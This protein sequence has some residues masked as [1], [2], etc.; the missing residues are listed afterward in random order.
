MTAVEGHLPI[1]QV[2]IPLLGAV[3]AAFLRRGRAA[4]A[5]TLMVSW[6][7]PVVAGSLLWRVLQSGPI[8]YAI[9]GWEPP[10]GI[11]YRIDLL[12]EIVLVLVSAVGAVAVPFAYRSVA[13][14]IGEDRQA[15]FYCMYLLCLAGLLGITAT[16][17]AFNAFV[18]LEISSLATY[19]LIALGRD[20]R[21]LIAAFQYLIMGTI[22][23]TFY[24]I[25]V[26]LLYLL[27]G[28]LN[29]VDIGARL[30]PAWA[31]H[32]RAVVAA[33][34]FITV[35]VSLKLALFPL[36]TW[37]PN[38]YAY[39]P[40]WVTAFL[41]ATATKVAIYLLIRFF[42]SI[43]GVAIDFR[44]LP[45]S[46]IIVALS[47]AAMLVASLVAVFETN[48]KRMLAYSSVAQIGYITLGIGLADQA[49]LTG[50]LVHIVNH[51]VMKAGLFLAAGAIVYR[52]GTVQ[53]RSWPVSAARCQ[54]R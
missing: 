7:M 8:S 27:T 28:S 10:W 26:G 20:R 29:M 14:E 32:S 50:G 49:G 9:G 51:A 54:S 36:H 6:V 31:D 38:A 30:S 18:F 23:A 43:F 15:W 33:L 41:S 52:V 47:V 40:S 21:A 2:V 35:G 13:T 46:D 5:L 16:G 24:V 1:L 25:G 34:A 17:D 11:E 45:I 19:V 53:F 37:L 12:N 42:F 4:F 44:A 39:A 22:G 48:L 3:L